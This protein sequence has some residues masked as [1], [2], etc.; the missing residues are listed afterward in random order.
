MWPLD[1]KTQYKLPLISQDAWLIFL[2]ALVFMY[3]TNL[4]QFGVPSNRHES[5]LTPEDVKLGNN[6][7][8][9]YLFLKNAGGPGVIKTEDSQQA[10]DRLRALFAINSELVL[11][12]AGKTPD[13]ASA[14]LNSIDLEEAA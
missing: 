7:P 14:I 12:C 6:D 13:E 4:E 10:H 3:M 1:V 8:L 11:S 2:P 9:Y 5:A